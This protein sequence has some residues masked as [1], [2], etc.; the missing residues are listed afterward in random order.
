MVRFQ[1]ASQGDD[2]TADLRTAPVGARNNDDPGS[3]MTTSGRIDRSMASK[4]RRMN[5]P[6]FAMN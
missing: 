3:S 4:S 6:M 5:A 2:A 1:H